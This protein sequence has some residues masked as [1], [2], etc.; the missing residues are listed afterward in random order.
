MQIT[1]DGFNFPND[2][3][4]INKFQIAINKKSFHLRKCVNKYF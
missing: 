2:E 3:I 4:T 1:Y